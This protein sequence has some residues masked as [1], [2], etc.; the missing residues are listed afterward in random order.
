MTLL[1]EV[2]QALTA[3]MKAQEVLR[4]STLRMVKSAL[5]NR[6]IE[7]MAPLDAAESLKVLQ[8][9]VKQR[10]D[11]AEQFTQAGRPELAEKEIAEIKVIEEYLPASLDETTLAR[12]VDE[13]LVEIGATS[14]KDM[15]RAM[16]AVMSKLGGQAV[17]GKIVSGLVKTKLGGC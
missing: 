13:T 11:S 15:G 10:R 2:T 1:E 16:K 4:L 17:D 6:E 12:L 5:K 3:A 7:K 8:T 9:L 14:A